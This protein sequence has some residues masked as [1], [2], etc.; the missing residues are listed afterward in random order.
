M[1]VVKQINW[2]ELNWTESNNFKII[3]GA[4]PLGKAEE[5]N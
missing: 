1:F 2:T 3:Y 4:G 5:A